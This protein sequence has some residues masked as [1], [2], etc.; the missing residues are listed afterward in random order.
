MRLS[1]IVV[2]IA[3]GIVVPSFAQT[4]PPRPLHKVGDHWTPYDPPQ[5]PPEGAEFY[6]IQPGDT[7]WDLARANLG[8][9]YLWPQIWE[10]NQYITDAH[11]IYPGDPLLITK[12][13][14]GIPEGQE[15]LDEEQYSEEW[16]STKEYALG[17]EVTYGGR[18]WRSLQNGNIGHVPEEGAW[19]TEIVPPSAP[20]QPAGT[21]KPIPLGDESDIYCYATVTPDDLDLP[22]KITGTDESSLRFTLTEGQIVYVNGGSE[23]GVKAGEEYF[24]VRDGGVI[25]SG[26]DTLGR[27]WHYTGRLI[28]L[29]TQE[30][31]STA[32]VV[33]ACQTILRGDRLMPFAAVPIPAKVLP[34]FYDQ[35]PPD[36]QEPVGSIIHGKDDLISLFQGHVVLVDLGSSQ[37]V[38]VGDLLRIFRSGTEEG[39]PRIVLGRLGILTVQERTATGR[40]LESVREIHVGDLVELE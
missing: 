10:Q 18:R 20:A 7:L 15:P 12:L 36:V 34:P 28:V 33:N 26:R 1:V 17:D 29:C 2:L 35:C 5:V 25:K 39:T 38:K 16:L 30:N 13:I 27:L 8:D 6:I 3:L 11:W 31:S 9:P 37:G 23:Q 19:W 32:K 4:A 14:E 22:L 40:I 21:A 24:I